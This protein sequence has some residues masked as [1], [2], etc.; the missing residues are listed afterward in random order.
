MVTHDTPPRCTVKAVIEEKE[1][2]K[3]YASM[4]DAKF[5]SEL[6]QHPFA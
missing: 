3:T 4:Q 6:S 1:N 2:E 5:V